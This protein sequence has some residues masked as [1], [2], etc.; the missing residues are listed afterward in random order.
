V[1]DELTAGVGDDVTGTGVFASV[2]DGY[3]AVYTALPESHTF[4]R[5]W[6]ANAYGGDFPEAF[7]HIGFLTLPEA[8]QVVDLLALAPGGVLVDVACGAGGPG[9]WMAQQTQ[10]TL[11]GVDP[12]RA[13]LTAAMERARHVDYAEQSRFVEGTFAQ[14]GLPDGIADAIVSIEAF[15]Y[16]PD[17]RD[18]FAEFRR[19]LRPGG[20]AAIV[21]FEVDPAKVAGVPVLGVDPIPDYAPL[22]ADAGLTTVSYV[23]TPGW[24]SRVYGTFGALVDAADTIAA[25]IGEGAAAGAL[26][27]AMVTVEMKPYPRRVLMVAERPG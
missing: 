26:A 7:A 5:I 3:D 1:S 2:R 25:D 10:A 22:I 16:A 6:R 24:Q 19:V 14:T 13:G 12:S 23:E 15:Q 21:C 27:E 9:L 18:A 11:I 20:R 4:S 8:R 17:K